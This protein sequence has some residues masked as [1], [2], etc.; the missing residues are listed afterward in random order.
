LEQFC[1]LNF[2]GLKGFYSK[3]TTVIQPE[4]KL[5]LLASKKELDYAKKILKHPKV[6][7]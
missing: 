7:E 2:H 3:G 5:L 4:D 6:Q 1:C